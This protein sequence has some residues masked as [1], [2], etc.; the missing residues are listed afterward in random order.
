MHRVSL[1]RAF[2]VAVTVLFYSA[3][4]ILVCL[5]IIFPSTHDGALSPS[6]VASRPFDPDPVKVER[7]WVAGNVVSC[8]TQQGSD[9]V[10]YV[11]SNE[12]GRNPARLSV[13]WRSSDGT[14]YTAGT[15]AG[16]AG[17]RTGPMV[18]IADSDLFK[19]ASE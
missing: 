19:V 6:Q 3:T 9:A 5:Q 11:L 1:R 15:R 7:I 12:I 18:L 17:Q 16:F 2:A 13:T 8:H 14:T 10:V 4:L